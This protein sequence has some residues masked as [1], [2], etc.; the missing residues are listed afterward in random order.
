[1]IIIKQGEE[2]EKKERKNNQPPRDPVGFFFFFFSTLQTFELNYIRVWYRSTEFETD[3]SL[4]LESNLPT[5][6]N[7]GP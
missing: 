5:V 2:E 3:G 6:G 7:L 4:L 1:M